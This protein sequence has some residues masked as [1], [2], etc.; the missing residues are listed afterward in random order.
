M[1]GGESKIA[2]RHLST[3]PFQISLLSVV[4]LAFIDFPKVIFGD[5]RLAKTHLHFVVN[6]GYVPHDTVKAA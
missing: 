3:T 6:P 4:Y 1:M 2:R 5:L